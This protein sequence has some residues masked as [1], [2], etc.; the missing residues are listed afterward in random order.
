MLRLVRSLNPKLYSPRTYILAK[1]DFTS[2]SKI[3]VVEEA[4]KCDNES[5]YNLERIPR[6]RNVG[7]SYFSSIFTTLYSILYCIPVMLI[8]RPNLILTNGPGTC[9]PICLIA[10][11]MKI[12]YLCEGTTVFVESVCRVTSLSL[13]GKI[14]L[15][16]ADV[17]IVQWPELQKKY[18][19]T[20][21]IGRLV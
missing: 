8:Q 14:L 20:K 16:F 11:V 1:G 5:N 12:F 17:V 18:K 3:H 7:Q 13:S 10:F 19:K 15:Y 4:L 6:S 2:E 9:I 21:Y